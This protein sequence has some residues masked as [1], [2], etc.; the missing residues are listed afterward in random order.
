MPTES[1]IGEFDAALKKLCGIDGHEAGLADED[2]AEW[3]AGFD[4]AEEAAEAYRIKYD[5]ETVVW[6][7]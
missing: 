4:G 3:V 6:E 5:L 2:I 1:S 7:R